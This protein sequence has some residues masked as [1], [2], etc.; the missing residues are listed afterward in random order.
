MGKQDF[1]KRAADLEA[2]IAIY[3]LALQVHTREAFP[4]DW[5]D[6]QF[7]LGF[8]YRNRIRGDRAKN[9][10]KAI[11]AYELALQVLTREA[12]PQNWANTQ[13]NLGT[14]YRNRIRGDRAENIEKA[15]AAYKLALQ[16]LTREAFP[17]G[18]ATIQ[19]N[20]GTAFRDREYGETVINLERAVSIYEQAAEVS[21][22]TAFPEQWAENQSDLAEAL[23]KRSL[24]TDNTSDLNFAIAIFQEV[25]EVA[26]PGSPYFI[27]AQYRLGNALSRRYNNSADPQDLNLALTAYKTALD[28][29]SPEHYD[30]SKIWQAL[31]TTQSILGS[32]LVRDGQWREGLQLLL[33]SARLLSTEEDALAHASTLFEIGRTYDSA[34]S[35]WNNARLYYRDALRLYTHLHNPLGMAKTRA[36]LGGVLLS[37][38]HFTQGLAELEKARD[39]YHN[40]QMPEQAAS[41]DRLYTIAQQK[42]PNQSIEVPA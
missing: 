7:G 33:N 9:I 34:L 11:T 5:A 27:D 36:G 37:Q 20:L 4:S 13:N 26:T 6:I 19:T 30:R 28:A 21:T 41:I 29:I 24:L 18:W 40:L 38:G 22:R 35:D 14:A 32:R 10:E 42:I 25:L 17:Q 15:I 39:G 2:K 23:V 16:V 31:P 8:A 1:E 12:F 3:E